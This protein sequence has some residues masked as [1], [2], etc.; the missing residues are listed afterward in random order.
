MANNNY[1]WIWISML[2]LVFAIVFCVGLSSYCNENFTNGFGNNVKEMADYPLIYTFVPNSFKLTRNFKLFENIQQLKYMN[3]VHKQNLGFGGTTQ[4][5]RLSAEN[6]IPVIVIPDLGCSSI[7]GMW[8]KKNSLKVKDLD[9]TKKFEKNTRWS[10][11]TEKKIW[12]KLWLKNSNLSNVLNMS[13]WADNIK[14]VD[15]DGS[16]TNSPGVKTEVN[17]ESLKDF[18]PNDYLIT[19]IDALKSLGYQEQNN[20]FAANY[21]FRKISDPGVLREYF[22]TLQSLCESINGEVILLGHGLGAAIGNMFLVS[23]SPEWKLRNIRAQL[24]VTPNLGGCPKALRVALSGE[25]V[26]NNMTRKKLKEVLSNFSGLLMSLPD[27]SVYGDETIVIMNTRKYNAQQAL[28][29]LNSDSR[30]IY[31][32]TVVPLRNL[33]KEAPGVNTYVFCG[34]DVPTESS[35]TYNTVEND[36]ERLYPPIPLFKSPQ[37]QTPQYPMYLSGDGV[38]PFS[39]MDIFNTWNMSPYRVTVNTYKVYEHN[40][41][42]EAEEPVM[43]IITTLMLLSELK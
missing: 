33:I 31:N 2:I 26:N 36:P 7:Y 21:D 1:V 27:P 16:I 3:G 12:T 15:N 11:S 28:T 19:F 8:D 4:I 9:I 10:C 37:T 29:L 41:I 5:Q 13:C 32:K 20:L 30:N 17:F 23:M 38:V 14:V 18:Q 35:F 42:L 6:V 43:D 40:K 25:N 34:Y 24:M 39:N 22:N